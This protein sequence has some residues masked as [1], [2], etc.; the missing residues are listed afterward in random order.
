MKTTRYGFSDLVIKA[1]ITLSKYVTIKDTKGD[2]V[3]E[4]EC[5]FI[6]NEDLKEDEV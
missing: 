6:E 1:D 2:I 5:Y 3:G 4:V